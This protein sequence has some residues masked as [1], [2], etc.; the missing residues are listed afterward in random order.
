[1]PARLALTLTLATAAVG[2]ALAAAP[3]GPG[4]RAPAAAA[5]PRAGGYTLPLAGEP[6]VAQP[7]VAPANPW[8]AGHRGVDLRAAAAD[9]VHAPAAGTVAFAGT[10]VDRGVLTIAHQGGLRSSLEPVDPA[11]SAGMSVTAGQAV[12]TVQP[13]AGHCAPATCLHWGVRRGERYLDPLG[14]LAGAGPVV[15]LP[16]G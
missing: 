11:V 2:L 9:V 8:A 10:V 16:G 7:F 15:L 13:V 1:M 6:A 3:A 4:D 14:L 12:G 5:S